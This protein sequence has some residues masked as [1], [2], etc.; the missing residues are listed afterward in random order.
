VNHLRDQW[1]SGKP[2]WGGWCNIPSSFSA[3]LIAHVGFDWIGIDCQ[4]GLIGPHEMLGMLLGVVGTG[5]PV[6]VRVQWNSPGEIMKVLDGGATGVIVPMVNSAEEARAAVGACRYPPNGYRSWGPTRASIGKPNYSPAA[7]NDETIC[8]VMIETV[9]AVNTIDDILSVPGIDAVFVGLADLS[10]SAGLP[11]TLAT[12]EANHVSR[13]ERVLEACRRHNVVPG[14]F[15]GGAENAL[16]WAAKGYQVI[17]LFSDSYHMVQGA[18]TLLTTVRSASE[19]AR[20][21]AKPH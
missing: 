6:L 12:A 13:V 15:A 16:A 20:P 2:S 19:R 18:R 10:L 3:E 17:A 7:A 21:E 1:S 8:A 11:P 4:H 14:M 9:D 5:T